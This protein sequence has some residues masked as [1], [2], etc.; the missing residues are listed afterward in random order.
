MTKV[1]KT[2]TQNG[3]PVVRGVQFAS[4]PKGKVYSATARY[5]V[6]LS[7]GAIGTPQIRTSS[8]VCC[9]I[10]VLNLCR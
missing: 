3:V 5:E 2:S 4:G 1:V 7:A 8:L 9:L 6:I 10:H